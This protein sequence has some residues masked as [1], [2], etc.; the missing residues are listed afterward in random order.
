MNTSNN[1]G[2]RY[3]L[4]D[5]IDQVRFW[6]SMFLAKR[7]AKFFLRSSSADFIN[8]PC[9]SISY[10][11]QPAQYSQCF[12]YVETEATMQNDKDYQTYIEQR[13]TDCGV[14]MIIVAVICVVC[15]SLFN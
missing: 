3:L 14:V 13:N 4:G 1:L 12:I 15:I 6:Q 7:S 11:S 5:T 2:M 10:S 9:K 8:T